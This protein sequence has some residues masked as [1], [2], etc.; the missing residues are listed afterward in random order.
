MKKSFKI[1][2]V[3]QNANGLKTLFCS[4]KQTDDDSPVLRGIRTV[5]FLNFAKKYELHTQLQGRLTLVAVELHQRQIRQLLSGKGGK[6]ERQQQTKGTG[7]AKQTI[8]AQ[9]SGSKI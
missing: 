4:M 7:I 2:T 8:S 6:A 3:K 5:T 1:K 9:Q